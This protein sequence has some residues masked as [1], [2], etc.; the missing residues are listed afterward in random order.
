MKVYIRK[1]GEISIKVTIINNWW[2]KLAEAEKDISK[3]KSWN[4]TPSCW[5]QENKKRR[6]FKRTR[7]KC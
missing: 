5:N 3:K 2:T 7:F 6:R 4:I 1:K